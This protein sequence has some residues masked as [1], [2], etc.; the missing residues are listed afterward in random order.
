MVHGVAKSWTRLSEQ[1]EGPFPL[2]ERGRLS[3][4]VKGLCR[5]IVE[6]GKTEGKFEKGG[7]K[8]EA[9]SG[10][11]QRDAEGMN[12]QQGGQDGGGRQE[13]VG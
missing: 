10:V 12:K 5:Q 2:E 1:M 6:R 8:L 3:Q 11:L 7:D 9:T 4:E 13:Q